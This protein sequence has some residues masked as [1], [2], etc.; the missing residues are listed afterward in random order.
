MRTAVMSQLNVDD[1]RFLV[2][3]DPG[4]RTVTSGVVSL[5][6]HLD[7]W[8]DPQAFVR[9]IPNPKGEIPLVIGCCPTGRARMSSSCL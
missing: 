3:T 5:Q 9:L 2:R 6:Q 1:S 4:Q 7:P 8:G